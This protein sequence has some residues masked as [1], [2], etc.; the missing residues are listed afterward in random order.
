[1]EI[2]EVRRRLDDLAD[3]VTRMIRLFEQ[4]TSC[5]VHDIRLERITQIGVRQQVL[6]RADFEARL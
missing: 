2:S 1:M 6:V 5:V 4:D 3:Q